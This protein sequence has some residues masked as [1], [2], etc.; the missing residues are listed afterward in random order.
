MTRLLRRCGIVLFAALSVAAQ[1]PAAAQVPEARKVLRVLFIGNS[2]TYVNNLPDIVAAI[3]AAD[4]DGPIIVP[5]LATRGGAT[6]R[7][8][9][10]NGSAVKL[11]D[12]GKWDFVVLQEQSTLSGKEGDGKVT[13]GEHAPFHAS[14]RDWA[15]RIRATGAMPMLFM[16]WARRNEPAMAGMQQGLA[17]AYDTIGRELEVT[18]APVGLA[19]GE[20]RRRLQSLDLHTWDASHPSS[21]GSYLAG[22]IM[23]STLTGKSP[24]GAPNVI[25][26]RPTVSSGGAGSMMAVDPTLKVPLVDLNLPT[27]IALQQVAAAVAA[28]RTSSVT[29]SR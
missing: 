13:L 23:Y 4:L 19:W 28:R 12:T 1:N 15:K 7:W 14:V 22:L 27:A 16:T 10:E 11:L 26:G 6:L 18:V 2:Y 20:A 8:H 25:Q 21:A 29:T 17:D 9:L 5:T 3:A 24:I